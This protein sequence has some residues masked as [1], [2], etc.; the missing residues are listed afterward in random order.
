LHDREDRALQLA[1]EYGVPK[2]KAF[3]LAVPGVRL[4][5]ADVLAKRFGALCD[6][7][8]AHGVDIA[9]ESL[10]FRPGFNHAGVVEVFALADRPDATVQVDMWHVF[11]DPAALPAIAQL[12]GSRSAASNC[13]T[14]RS[15]R[16]RT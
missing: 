11:R 13:A 16:P 15:R 1:E 4:A 9:L 6:R 14:G 8:A 10:S 2:V 5:P 7:A 12:T 3:A